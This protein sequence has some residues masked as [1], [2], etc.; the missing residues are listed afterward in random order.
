[1]RFSAAFTI[2]IFA[3]N[4]QRTNGELARNAKTFQRTS[5]NPPNKSQNHKRHIARF[6]A[7]AT[8]TNAKLQ[9]EGAAVLAPLGAFGYEG[10]GCSR[11]YAASDFVTVL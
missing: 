1:M 4:A 6:N 5:K 9:N 7:T 8:A 3:E 11:R 10:V 2:R